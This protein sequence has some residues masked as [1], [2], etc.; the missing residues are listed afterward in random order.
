MNSRPASSAT[1]PIANAPCGAA[2]AVSARAW[3]A[4]APPIPNTMVAPNSIVVPNSAPR[5]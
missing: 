2:D 4:V 3:Y 1:A 5:R